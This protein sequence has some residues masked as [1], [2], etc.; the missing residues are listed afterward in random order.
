MYF[1]KNNILKE[2]KPIL[3]PVSACGGYEPNELLPP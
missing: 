3:E 2:Q 1:Y